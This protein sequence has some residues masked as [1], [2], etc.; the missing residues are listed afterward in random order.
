MASGG[1]SSPMR[2]AAVM[3]L[4]G[5]VSFGLRQLGGLSSSA[6]AL[7]Q[8]SVPTAEQKK[9]EQEQRTKKDERKGK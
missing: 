5:A 2:F 1:E 7:K 4:L 3:V 8:R 6:E 9:K